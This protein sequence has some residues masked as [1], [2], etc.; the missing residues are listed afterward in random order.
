MT[1]KQLTEIVNGRL[2]PSSSPLDADV[3]E[4]SKEQG[5]ALQ[6]KE[7][8]L[9]FKERLVKDGLEYTGEYLGIED[10]S[11]DLKKIAKT[12]S[13]ASSLEVI[14]ETVQSLEE[15]LANL[16]GF[17]QR[18]KAEVT[19]NSGSTLYSLQALSGGY[20]SLQERLVRDYYNKD[21]V[22]DSLSL[23]AD[24]IDLEAYSTIIETNNTIDSKITMY[25]QNV[26]INKFR[27]KSEP[28]STTAV[29][30]A[31]GVLSTSP[32]IFVGNT[33]A[34]SGGD[35]SIDYSH[36]GFT[37]IPTVIAM[38]Q[39]VG[40]SLADKRF[41]SLNQ[42]QPTKT[43]CSGKLL[44]S[45]SSSAGLLAAMTM[46]HGAGPVHVVAIGF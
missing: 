23:K 28:I 42:N 24:K 26:A 40:T 19:E 13:A 45:S 31:S 46:V 39:N 7:D 18:L 16:Y 14:P 1:V 30:N 20:E 38:G 33:T 6:V 34:N 27:L 9:Y 15:H 12:S 41:T 37:E 25:D 11:I 10:Y 4:V 22:N 3:L 5:N 8:G 36:V 35:W 44:S 29:Y 17:V 2:S 21:S 32:K 43:G